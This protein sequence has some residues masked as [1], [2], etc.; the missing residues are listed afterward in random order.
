MGSNNKS[1][2]D[3][4]NVQSKITQ[5]HHNNT[6]HRTLLTIQVEDPEIIN[7]LETAYSKEKKEQEMH[8]IRS[9]VQSGKIPSIIANSGA[10]SHCGSKDNRF[11]HTCKP[12]TKVFHT[13]LEQ[14][15]K[16]TN[17]AKLIHQVQ[18]PARMV[19]I[20]PGFQSSSLLSISKFANTNYVTILT[21]NDVSIMDDNNT[22]I[23]S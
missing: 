2:Q 10:T 19:H 6:Q 3:N 12:S 17:K 21:P 14:M 13:P 4:Q 1:A 8:N 11:I 23:A 16:S 20:I 5:C 15:A 9:D 22:K 18:E 7:Q